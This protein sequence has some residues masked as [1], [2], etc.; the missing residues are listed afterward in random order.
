MKM[1][2]ISIPKPASRLLTT[3]SV[4]CAA[5]HNI[6]MYMP[7]QLMAWRDQQQVVTAAQITC[8]DWHLEFWRAS[9]AASLARL[10]GLKPTTAVQPASAC[11]HQQQAASL[12][13]PS[14][15][16][17]LQPT[18][19]LAAMF[20][21]SHNISAADSCRS[22]KAASTNC[23]VCM[24]CMPAAWVRL[25]ADERQQPLNRSCC[26]QRFPVH[27][28]VPSCPT[29]PKWARR[30]NGQDVQHAPMLSSG[31]SALQSCGRTCSSLQLMLPSLLRSK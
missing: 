17:P 25:T 30:H 5:P 23:H 4:S 8:I 27:A 21:L 6:H 15:R 22:M 3:L 9:D 7:C 12:S 10:V 16:M 26:M 14:C 28:R 19:M 2:W 31:W 18:L 1:K 13:A 11:T 20:F 24:W 29:Q